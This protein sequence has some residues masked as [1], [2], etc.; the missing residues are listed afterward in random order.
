[1]VCFG[2]FRGVLINLLVICS[3]S[4]PSCIAPDVDSPLT[5][6]PRKHC[7]RC[8]FDEGE[9]KPSTVEREKVNFTNEYIE[10]IIVIVEKIYTLAIVKHQAKQV[11][12]GDSSWEHN[13]VSLCHLSL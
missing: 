9:S 7:G 13:T 5:L 2:L 3:S 1:M 6:V 12:A 8:K 10:S 11:F 4:G